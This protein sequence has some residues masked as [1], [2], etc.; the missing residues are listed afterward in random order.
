MLE[1]SDLVAGYGA[2]EV[3]RGV[4]FEVPAGGCVCL[5][6]GNGAGKSTTMRAVAGL[7]RVRGG[8]VRL[9]GRDIT[10][11]PPDARLAAGLALV[12]EGRRVFAPLTVAEN[13]T[14]G[15]YRAPAQARAR[16]DRVLT[17]FPRLAERLTQPAGTLSG[18][19]QQMLAIGRAMMS[20][21]R[22]LLLDE[23]SMGL[24]PIVLRAIFQSVAALNGEGLAILLAEQNARQALRV[25]SGG[26]VL[27]DGV[28]VV[29][30]D[31][32]ALQ[33]NPAVREAYL[34]V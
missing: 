24:A 13:L 3:L 10:H 11:L 25:A 16:R 23:P 27:A 22:L 15:A 2:A 8:T 19:E 32:A 17:L 9:E 30:G 1:V 4:S 31:A 20:G 34:G 14:I 5:L 33:A 29:R 28:I 7:L 21:P 6:G 12:P 18:G 26:M